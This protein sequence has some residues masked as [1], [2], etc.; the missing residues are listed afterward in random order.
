SG[1]G[2]EENGMKSKILIFGGTGYIGNHMVKGSLKLGHPTYVFTRP[3]SSKT[4]LLD[5]FQSLGAIIVK[6]ELDEHEK[7]VEL[8]KKVDVVIS[9]LAFPQIL[10][11]FKILEA[12]KVAGNIKRFLPSDFGVEEDRINALPP[13]EAL[14]ERKR[15]IRRAIEEANIPYTYVSANC[16]ASY[17]INYLLR[18][19][20]PKDEITVYG[21]GEAKFAMNYEQDI[22]LYTIKVATDPRAL[23][24]VVIYRPSTNIIT[25]LELISRWEKKIGKKF[26]KIHVPEEEIVALTKE[27][28]EPE[29]IP[30]AILH[31]LFIDGATMSYDF[32][33][34]DVEASTLYPE[35]K[36]TT[37]DEL[38]DIFVHDP[39]PPASAA[40]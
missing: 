18:P 35:L 9:A 2:M 32:K 13:F 3:N 34:N 29:N 21:T 15:M 26:K 38:L 12:I 1:H 36:F 4:T 30:I 23:N 6:G 28:P 20:D 31:C 8:M 7:L 40:F 16:F 5:E 37:I 24:R 17:F 11:Q 25:Q 10:D 33:E 22:G 39:P 19:Y 27:L 14:I